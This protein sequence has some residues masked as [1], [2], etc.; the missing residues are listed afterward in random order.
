MRKT[1]IVLAAGLLL[2][3][4][5]RDR[6]IRETPQPSLV[7]IGGVAMLSM[8]TPRAL[9]S[10]SIL[11]DGRIL[12][13]GGN[14]S[15]EIGG[16]L[17]S[18]EIF[19]PKTSDFVVTSEMTVQRQGHTATVLKDGR[20]LITG[21]TSNVGFRSELSSAEIYD[22]ATG[23]FSP[24][25]RMST[26]R[27][28]HTATLLRDGR[29]LVA[30]GSPN[31]IVTT[32]S[33]EIYDPATGQFSVTGPLNRPRE[34]HTATLLRDGKVLVAGGGRGGMPGGYVAFDTAEIYDPVSGTF[35]VLT[36]RMHGAR[37]GAGAAMLRD[38]RVLVVGGKT[39]RVGIVGGGIP[40]FAPLN[41]ADIFD[42]ETNSFVR[43]TPMG[44][45]HYITV[46]TALDNAQVLVTGGFLQQGPIVVGMKAADVYDPS[47]NAFFQPRQLRIG[48]LNQTATLLDSGLVMIA[49]GVDETSHVTALVEFYDPTM[50]RFVASPIPHSTA[51]TE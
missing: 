6:Y 36:S 30:G 45:A 14:R 40:S 17:S 22:P 2:S 34:A 39:N 20:V 47:L 25:G 3:A 4:C 51:A 38:G 13:A 35:S 27:E 41:T 24:T 15:S 29:V 32:D 21:G 26:P 11:H 12:I 31:G 18:A 1:L 8:T 50:R 19:D 10:A 37:V 49:G 43:A 28:G 23:R 9:H 42:P 33:A 48:R 44:Q 16:V 5:A 46:A 7:E